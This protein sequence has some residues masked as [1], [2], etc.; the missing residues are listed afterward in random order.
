MHT[1]LYYFLL[2]LDYTHTWS[3]TLQL[4]ETGFETMLLHRF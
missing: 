1:Y 4:T 2:S 3:M